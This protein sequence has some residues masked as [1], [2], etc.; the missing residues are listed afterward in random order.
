MSNNEL[1]VK[2]QIISPIFTDELL[3]LL[4]EYIHNHEYD[5]KQMKKQAVNDKSFHGLIKDIAEK[6]L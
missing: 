2:I 6:R 4:Y 5:Y 3:A 1:K